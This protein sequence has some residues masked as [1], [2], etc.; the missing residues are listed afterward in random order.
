MEERFFLAIAVLLTFPVAYLRYLIKDQLLRG[1]FSSCVDLL[2]SFI[3]ICL[4]YDEKKFQIVQT[5]CATHACRVF[6]ARFF[7]AILN[8]AGKDSTYTML[9]FSTG[10]QALDWAIYYSIHVAIY[11]VF[12]LIFMPKGDEVLSNRG[13]RN[14]TILT[15]FSLIVTDFGY[16]FIRPYESEH[17]ILTGYAKALTCFLSVVILFIRK[18]IFASSKKEVEVQLMND[19]FIK[20]REHFEKS[21]ENIDLINSK[22]HD[23]RKK[24]SVLEGKVSEEEIASLKDATRIYD[25][26][27][28]TGNEIL[29]AVLYEYQLLAE[30]SKIRIT[31]MCDGSLLSFMDTSELYMLFSNLLSNAIRALEEEDEEY[32]ILDITLSKNKGLAILEINNYCHKEVK[33]DSEGFPLSTKSDGENHGFGSRSIGYVVKK[34]DGEIKYSQNDGIFRIT[35]AF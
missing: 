28:K 30:K 1:W 33:F 9:L 27:I 7:S 11:I 14:I 34:Y 16:S 23:L 3:I 29:D 21:R 32:R 18:G 20:E 13:K 2:Y 31:S 10:V 6:A 25:S 4:T 12:G 17:I 15:V 5:F 26:T 22:C 24:L 19:L 8:F 35:I